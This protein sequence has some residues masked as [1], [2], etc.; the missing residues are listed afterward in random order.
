MPALEILAEIDGADAEMA[1]E[2]RADEF[3]VDQRLLLR[4]LRLR[5]LELGGVAVDVAWLIACVLTSF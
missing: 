1:G 3:L 4:H 5:V 2:G